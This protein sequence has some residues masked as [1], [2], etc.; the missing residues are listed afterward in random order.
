MWPSKP[1]VK[2]VEFFK[3]FAVTLWAQLLYS[4]GNA[5]T[6][7]KTRGKNVKSHVR[8]MRVEIWEYSI[9]IMLGNPYRFAMVELRYVAVRK[10][11]DIF[12]RLTYPLDYNVLYAWTGVNSS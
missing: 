2:K 12:D 11:A 6:S 8:F 7:I 1:C 4:N 9:F 10:V 3:E 5:L